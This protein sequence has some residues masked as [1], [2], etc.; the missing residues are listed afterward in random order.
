M[1][2]LRAIER[3]PHRVCNMCT[4]CSLLPKVSWENSSEGFLGEPYRY[5]MATFEALSGRALAPLA[6]GYRSGVF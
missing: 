3:K 4:V 1:I 6:G 2:E 5:C